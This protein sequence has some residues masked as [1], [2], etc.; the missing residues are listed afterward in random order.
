M[1]NRN[2]F[3]TSQLLRDVCHSTYSNQIV[4]G[5]SVCVDSLGGRV[6]SLDT[7]HWTVPPRFLD[8]QPSDNRPRGAG[9]GSGQR[10]RRSGRT[11]AGTGQLL[12]TSTLEPS[13]SCPLRTHQTWETRVSCKRSSLTQRKEATGRTRGRVRVSEDGPKVVGSFQGRRPRL[14]WSRDTGRSE[15]PSLLKEVTSETQQSK[16][17]IEELKMK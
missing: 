17:R 13:L 8:P 10:V 3:T 2:L 16:G 7:S 5:I 6:V 1:G 11:K 12:S 4:S 15:T 14:W 9:R